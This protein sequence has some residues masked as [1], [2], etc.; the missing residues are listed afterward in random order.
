MRECFMLTVS[1]DA[2]SKTCQVK[3]TAQESYCICNL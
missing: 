1:Y 2:A 3:N